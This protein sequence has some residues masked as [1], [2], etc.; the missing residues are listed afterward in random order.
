M[1]NHISTIGNLSLKYLVFAFLVGFGVLFFGCKPKDVEPEYVLIPDVNFEKA[2]INLKIDDVQDGKV[3]RAKAVKVNLLIIPGDP[4]KPVNKIRSISGIEAFVNLY[5]LDC[6]KNSIDNLDLSKNE[7]LVE[8][9]CS[10]N[11]IKQLDLSANIDLAFLNCNDNQLTTINLVK[12]NGLRTIYCESNKLISLDT[13]TAPLLGILLCVDN[14][15]T[16]LDIT[17]N[18]NLIFFKCTN[19]NIQ[20]ICVNNLNQVTSNWQKDP[21]ATYK[22]CP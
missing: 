10:S 19:N 6:S 15:L 13:R 8:F 16:S 14:Q 1:K 9:D 4:Q 18:L 7:A 11:L 21:T 22:V 20:T 5:A 2:L 3:L 17:K 12:N